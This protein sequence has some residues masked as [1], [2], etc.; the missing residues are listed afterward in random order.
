MSFGVGSIEK[1]DEKGS[2]FGATCQFG[3]AHTVTPV[4]RRSIT[5]VEARKVRDLFSE[6]WSNSGP[7]AASLEAYRAV[8]ADGTEWL[9][10][11]EGWTG[12]RPGSW[13][14]ADGRRA[15]SASVADPGK[16]YGSKASGYTFT[17]LTTTTET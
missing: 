6:G 7:R 16:I 9:R 5:I 10:D 2:P 11:W 3:C 4:T 12:D 17:D 15:E 13:K 1:I 8:D 14:T